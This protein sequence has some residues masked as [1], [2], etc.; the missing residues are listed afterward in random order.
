VAARRAAALP[1]RV[2]VRIVGAEP[3]VRRDLPALI[4]TVRDAGHVSILMT[5]GLKLG[6]RRYVTA[7]K[8]AGL[9]T[10]YLL[11]NGGFDRRRVRGRRRSA[12]RGA[13]RV[14]SRT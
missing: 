13:Q 6:Q 5:N 4:R 7:L 11:F 9:R 8:N 1:R 14:L 10:V 3:T 2:Q 12:L